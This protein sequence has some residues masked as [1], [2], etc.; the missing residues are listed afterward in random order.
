MASP[1]SGLRAV[2]LF[3][4]FA[5]ACLPTAVKDESV[6]PAWVLCFG[7]FCSKYEHFGVE[8]ARECFFGNAFTAR[9]ADAA[10]CNFPCTGIADEKYGAGNR[11]NIFTNDAFVP[12][13]TAALDVLY[14]SCFV[15]NGNPRIL[16]DNALGANDMTAAKC[17]A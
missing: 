4:I 12:I 15:D 17:Q 9:T 11:L 1:R 8:Y 6:H 7:L 5:S 16:P 3:C 10:D 2:S 13:G 14:L